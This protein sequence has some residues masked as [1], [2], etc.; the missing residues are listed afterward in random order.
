MRFVWG[1]TMTIE[2]LYNSEIR[3]LP[4]DERLRLAARII[5]DLAAESR[6]VDESDSWS[7]DDLR[8]FTRSG[9]RLIER[10]LEESER[11]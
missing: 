10:R 9:T 2:Q 4:P 6:V 1:R 8:D 7:D 5:N 11:A 3:T